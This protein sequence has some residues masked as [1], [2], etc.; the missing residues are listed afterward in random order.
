MKR[1]SLFV[2]LTLYLG[3]KKEEIA[4]CDDRIA[5]SA[6]SSYPI[7]S[8]KSPIQS[9]LSVSTHTDK[10]LF[11]DFKIETNNFISNLNMEFSPKFNLRRLEKANYYTGIGISMNPVNSLLIIPILLFS[12]YYAQTKPDNMVRNCFLQVSVNGV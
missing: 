10:R 4:K 8:A 9:I 7:G 3:C 12:F 11:A 1:I 6:L 2:L 5:L